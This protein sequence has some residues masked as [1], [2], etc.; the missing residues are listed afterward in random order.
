L[1]GSR[2]SKNRNSSE[3]VVI[4]FGMANNFLD[5]YGKHYACD[6]VDKFTGNLLF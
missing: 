2:N 1:L 4:D 5:E 6:S 3:I